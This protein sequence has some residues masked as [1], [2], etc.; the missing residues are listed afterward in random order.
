MKN[1]LQFGG[2]TAGPGPRD[3]VLRGGHQSAVTGEPDRIE[4]PQAPLIESD[5][6]VE[7]IEGT[8]MRVTGTVRKLLQLAEDSDVGLRTQ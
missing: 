7:S 3:A 6:L 4:R 8:P 5:N 1:V 2:E